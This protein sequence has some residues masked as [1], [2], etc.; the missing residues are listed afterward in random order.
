MPCCL[1]DSDSPRDRF[2]GVGEVDDDRLPLA[3]CLLPPRPPPRSCRD[4]CEVVEEVEVGD[5]PP[6]RLVVVVVVVVMARRATLPLDPDR[7]RYRDRRR[8]DSD[9][10]RDRDRCRDLDRDLD[11]DLDFDLDR[12][13]WRVWVVRLVLLEGL[14]PYLLPLVLVCCDCFLG[15][16]LVVESVVVAGVWE[17]A[18]ES[19]CPPGESGGVELVTGA[20]TVSLLTFTSHC[21]VVLYL[22]ASSAN[23]T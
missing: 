20:N 19:A 3:L 8:G 21:P 5:P 4:R 11:L 10:D 13:L 23:K 14:R 15:D 9:R 16:C 6:A 2:E 1:T 12:R 17:E 7:D 18:F 22:L